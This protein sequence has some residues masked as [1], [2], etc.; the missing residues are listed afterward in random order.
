MPDEQKKQ[1]LPKGYMVVTYSKVADSKTMEAY[2]KLALP[3]LGAFGAHF[4]L[5]APAQA[6]DAR[7]SGLQERVVVIEF[8]SRDGAIAAYESEAYQAA[9]QVLLGKVER[10]VRFAEGQAVRESA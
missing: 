3:A 4:L 10:D 9:L 1:T 6:V 8:P 2:A 7:E 5:R